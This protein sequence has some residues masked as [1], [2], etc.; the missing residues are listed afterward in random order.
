MTPAKIAMR[1]LAAAV[2]AALVHGPALTQGSLLKQGE[3]LLGSQGTSGPLSMDKIISELE[4]QGYSKIS[5][6]MPASAGNALQATAQSPAG[7]LVQLLI[8]PSNG[9]VISA[10][11]K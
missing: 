11:P 7:K 4:Q 10:T 1:V 6:L 9:Q 5:G 2:L 3:G 8:N